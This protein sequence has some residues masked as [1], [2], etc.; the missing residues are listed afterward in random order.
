MELYT[1]YTKK[2]LLLNTLSALYVTLQTAI[3]DYPIKNTGHERETFTKFT[4]SDFYNDLDVDA[5]I[6]ES[7]KTEKDNVKSERNKQIIAFFAELVNNS[8]R[9]VLD[10]NRNISLN[11]MLAGIV[12]MSVSDIYRK[13]EL[14]IKDLQATAIVDTLYDE[15][16]TYR[17]ALAESFNTEGV[18]LKDWTT[19]RP[20]YN[21]NVVQIDINNMIKSINETM[22]K[23]S[24][25]LNQRDLL[26][27]IKLY[28]NRLNNTKNNFVFAIS[29]IN[30]L[31]EYVSKSKKL[32]NMNFL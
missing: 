21:P 1:I 26:N 25:N 23:Y 17:T 28:K 9:V 29:L 32:V 5:G 27:P 31:N 11:S 8:K 10:S 30:M 2:E 20:S 7:N 24:K 16:Y 18:Y 13:L 6:Q 3:P 15:K 22:S 14:K 19:F 12:N 4:V